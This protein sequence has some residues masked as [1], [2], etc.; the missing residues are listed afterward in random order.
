MKCS[1]LN[2]DHQA[3]SFCKTVLI[4]FGFRQEIQGDMG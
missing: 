3:G 2:K 4:G 1:V